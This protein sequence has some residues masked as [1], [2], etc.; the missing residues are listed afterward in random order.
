[1]ALLAL[2]TD[3]MFTGQEYVWKKVFTD[4]GLTDEEVGQLFTRPAFLAWKR[5]GNLQT[6]G[7]P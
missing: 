1:M 4:N 5:M 6:F 3:L 7:R 2:N